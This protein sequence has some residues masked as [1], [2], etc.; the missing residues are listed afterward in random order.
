MTID[1]AL[2]RGAALTREFRSAR[3]QPLRLTHV[4]PRSAAALLAADEEP[5]RPPVVEHLRRLA[6][7]MLPSP[8]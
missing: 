4:R 1:A 3:R 6:R 2:D 8:V 5:D 7:R